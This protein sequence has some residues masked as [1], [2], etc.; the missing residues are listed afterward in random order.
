MVT[1]T[2]RSGQISS[3]LKKKTYAVNISKIKRDITYMWSWLLLN[4]NRKSYAVCHH[5]MW[6]VVLPNHREGP[7][8][9]RTKMTI[10][11]GVSVCH[12]L[13]DVISSLGLLDV[14]G[15][16][17]VKRFAN[18]ALCIG[19]LSCPVL[20]VCL[21]VTLVYRGQTVGWIKI[22]LSTEVGL[23][24][25]DILLVRDPAA[26]RKGAQ[27]PPTFRPMSIVAKRSPIS[28]TVVL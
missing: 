5:V 17:F 3:G 11:R 7:K 6:S 13:N 12:N 16:R 28:A 24:A 21:S 18:F 19:P 9:P 8:W 22:P 2:S 1:R 20:Y 25:G 4:V 10:G 23:S 15:R 26:P 14:F 27:Q